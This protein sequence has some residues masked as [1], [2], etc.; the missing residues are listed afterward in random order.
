VKEVPAR[1]TTMDATTE[2]W[3]GTGQRY[4]RRRLGAA[5]SPEF[6]AQLQFAINA[7]DFVVVGA[8]LTGLRAALDLVTAGASVSVLEARERVGGRTLSKSIPLAGW[9]DVVLDV[10]A[11]WIGPGQREI[12]KLVEELGLTALPTAKPGRTTWALGQGICRSRGWLPPLPPA[13]LVDLGR[14]VFQIIRSSRKLPM[15]EPWEAPRANYWDS[16]TV[17]QWAA[18]QFLTPPARAMLNVFV[19]GN[20]AVNPRDISFLALLA[21]LRSTGRLRDLESSEAFRIAEGAQEVAVRLA[22]R[23][24]DRVALGEAVRSISQARDRITVVSDNRSLNCKAVAICIPPALAGEL[25]YEPPLPVEHAQLLNNLPMGSAVKFHAVYN[26]AFWRA[27]E[28]SG[29]AFSSEHTVGLTY[30]NSPPGP[31]GPGVLVGL[32]VA[33]QARRLA[34]LSRAEQENEILSSLE[35]FFGPAA[36]SPRYVEVHDWCVEEWSR[37]C[38]AAYFAPHV[39]TNWGQALRQ[40]YGRVYWASTETSPSWSGYMEG[41]LREGRRVARDLLKAAA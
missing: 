41:A 21:D 10:G 1:S 29:A 25:R 13:G 17:E 40:P 12:M 5:M 35:A 23:L 15:G 39:W 36:R 3:L 34:T 22:R 9:D 32:V 31:G 20:I 37:G 4:R 28:L 19:T 6:S 27:D 8:G 2:A 7:P 38:Y 14:A 30:D 16:L 24:G 33:D 26:E 11:Q 18:E